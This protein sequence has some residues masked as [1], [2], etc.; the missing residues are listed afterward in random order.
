MAGRS[1][2]PGRNPGRAE[3]SEG[4]WKLG[5]PE[6]P[7]R[8]KR[9]R[10]GGYLAEKRGQ[11]HRKG[12]WLLDTHTST[13]STPTH[14]LH[15]FQD[16][17]QLI[18]GHL[19]WKRSSSAPPDKGSCGAPRTGGVPSCSE[20]EA[21]GCLKEVGCCAHPADPPLCSRQAA[22]LSPLPS[23]CP[24][25]TGAGGGRGLLRRAGPELC[26]ETLH[27]QL[28]RFIGKAT[29]R[30]KADP[31]ERCLTFPVVM[32]VPP[33]LPFVFPSSF[34]RGLKCYCRE[35]KFPLN[36]APFSSS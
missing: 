1:G 28:V 26:R 36:P 32:P 4:F 25:R 33:F 30:L 16:Q 3:A 18:T 31:R 10:E 21:A 2:L 7:Q 23:P 12:Q 29:P 5:G 17:S 27:F 9:R 14:P 20:Q 35:W 11:G 22:L 8:L 34:I 6:N 24:P 15:G 13:Q 19:W